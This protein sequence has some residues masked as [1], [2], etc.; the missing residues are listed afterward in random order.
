MAPVDQ[1]MT[2]NDISAENRD[3]YERL[4]ETGV[5]EHAVR[6]TETGKLTI[7]GNHCPDALVDLTDEDDVTVTSFG[8]GSMTLEVGGGSGLQISKK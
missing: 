2:P 7:Y 1:H 3:L 4:L 8:P 6:E 5:P